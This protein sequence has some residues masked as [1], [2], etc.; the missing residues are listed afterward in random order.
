MLHYMQM[1][2]W[3]IVFLA[4]TMTYMIHQKMTQHR[5]ANTLHAQAIVTSMFR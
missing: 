2:N 5:F 1:R 3:F 4:L